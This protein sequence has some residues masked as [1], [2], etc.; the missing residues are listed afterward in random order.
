MYPVETSSNK[1]QC[2]SEAMRRVVTLTK[3]DNMLYEFT[4]T[5]TSRSHLVS[6]KMIRMSFEDLPKASYMDNVRPADI[7]NIVSDINTLVNGK[8]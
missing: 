1:Y 6:N 7:N 4:A 8:L 5:A 2:S 3:A